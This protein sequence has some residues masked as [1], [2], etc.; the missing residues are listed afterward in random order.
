LKAALI[1]GVAGQ[2]G[3]LLAKLWH[4]E[5]DS[6]DDFITQFINALATQ[7][8]DI[9]AYPER[10]LAQ[11]PACLEDF[12]LGRPAR[13]TAN[14]LKLLDRRGVCWRRMICDA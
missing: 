5:T 9:L 11:L 6:V 3:P 8:L 7:P 10:L 14:A 12:A 2:D 4:P 1:C 13:A